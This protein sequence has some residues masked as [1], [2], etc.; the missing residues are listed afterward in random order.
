MN[1]KIL[2]LLLSALLITSFFAFNRKIETTTYEINSNKIN[3]AVKIAVIAD[4]HSCDYGKNQQTLLKKLH[5]EKPDIVVLVGD[6]IDDKLPKTKAKE[7]LEGIKNKYPTYYVSGNHEFWTND[8]DGIKDIIK[9]YDISI[10][11][12]DCKTVKIKDETLNICGVDDPEVGSKEFTKQLESTKQKENS[13]NFSILLSHRPEKIKQYLPLNHDLI[14]SGHAHGGQWRIPFILESGL[15]SPHQGI[16]PKYT[17]GQHKFKNQ[18]FIVSRGL[19]KESTLIP[20][21]FNR[22]ELVIININ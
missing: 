1:K 14:I 4:L 20:K 15:Y 11:E 3:S 18:D 13:A 2:I 21:I 5:Q 22:P 8:I 17:T 12:G 16:F 10:L 19:A 9:A 6:I 7:L